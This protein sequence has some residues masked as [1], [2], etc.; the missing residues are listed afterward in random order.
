MF[1]KTLTG[2]KILRRFIDKIPVVK[3]VLKQ[4]AFQRFAS[5]LSSLLKAGLPILDA[6]EI[7]ASTVGSE[8]LK[9]SL[10]CGFPAR[11]SPKD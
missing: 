8:E 1:F 4:L 3:N 11:E 5:T 2:K 10:L 9:N 7:T 6:L